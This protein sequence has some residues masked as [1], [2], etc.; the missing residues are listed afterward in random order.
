[1]KEENKIMSSTKNE[2]KTSLKDAKDK[3]EKL[4]EANRDLKDRLVKIKEDYTKIKIDYDNLLIA[5]EL[6]S[7]N[8]HE[9]I[10]PV[11]KIDVATSCDDLSQVDQPSLHDDLIEKV[12]VM[13]LENQKLKKYLIDATTRGKVG[14]E[15]ND[16]NNELGVDDERLRDEVKKL[17]IEKEHLATSVQKFNKGQYLQNE[18]LMN[19]V[20]KNNKSGIGYNSFVQKK[21]TSQYKARQ[22]HKP[23]KCFE[24]GKGHFAHNCK[25]TPPTPLP[26]HSRPF[27]FNAHYVLRKVANGKVKVTFQGPPSKSRPRQISVAKSLIE[28]VTGSMQNRALKIEA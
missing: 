14:I 7:C 11:V 10:N 17:K 6:L 1:M 16:I 28:K 9:A 25:A 12:E 20:M 27:A 5:N 15:S 18:L 2:L 3:Y 21:A 23:I 4:S 24:C 26:K 8:T 13:T 22:T 19:T